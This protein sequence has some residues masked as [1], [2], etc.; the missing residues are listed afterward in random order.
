MTRFGYHG[1]ILHVDLAARTTSVEEPD[2]RFYRLYA[3][4]GLLGLLYQP[5]GKR[6]VKTLPLPGLLDTSMVPLCSSMM[7]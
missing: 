2:E 4:V 6:I 7:R 1:R 5:T 3:R